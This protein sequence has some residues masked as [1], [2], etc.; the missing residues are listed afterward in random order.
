M[1]AAVTLS[2]DNR[3]KVQQGD[4]ARP[5]PPGLLV[6]SFSASGEQELGGVSLDPSSHAEGVLEWGNWGNMCY[7]GPAF[8]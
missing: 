5:G 7:K 8:I 2:L 4:A 6:G 3:Y 1:G